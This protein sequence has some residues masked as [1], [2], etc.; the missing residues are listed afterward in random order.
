MRYTYP[1]IFT[2]EKNGY[3]VSF[4]DFEGVFSEG[5]T[6]EQAIDMSA[7]ALGMAVLHYIDH[8]MKLPEPTETLD[9][10]IVSVEVDTRDALISTKDA[11]AMLG[12][13]PSRVRQ[14]VGS[15]Q[16]VS[17]KQGRDNF[18]YLWSV[19]NRLSSPRKTGRP[20]AHA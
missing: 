15:G 2:K 5:D 9:A 4:P 3:S 7:E 14:M 18:V 17:K 16:L 10:A 13:N 1:A 12:V 8:G 6:F 20:K 19:R 11:A